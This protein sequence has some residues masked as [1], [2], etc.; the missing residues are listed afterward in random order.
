METDDFTNINDPKDFK[1]AS[2]EGLII[3]SLILFVI[4]IIWYNIFKHYYYETFSWVFIFLA[5]SLMVF[6]TMVILLITGIYVF[7]NDRHYLFTHESLGTFVIIIGAVTLFI[8]PIGWA[9]KFIEY[10][11][12]F[13]QNSSIIIVIGTIIC[14]LGA[15][16]LARTGGFF[17]T[18]MLGVGIYLTQSFHESF[19]FIVWTGFFGPYDDF[20]G[21]VGIFLVVTSFILFL[22]HDLKFF[23]LH[24]IIKMG[25]KYRREKNYQKALNCFNK[26]LKIYPLFTTA[27]NNM[28]NVYFNQ[29]KINQAVKC[30][31]KALAINPK[32]SN[33]KKNL[34]VVARRIR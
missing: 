27:W 13:A 33:A 20:V 32:Y 29:G 12:A 22:Y 17:L 25:N 30:Y 11:G 9:F 24:R 23:Y 15:L 8:L 6:V 2:K 34:E 18:W 14:V 28:G 19:R 5:Y 3:V 1:F 26:T 31:N 4:Y 7:Y 10:Q 21:N 16:I